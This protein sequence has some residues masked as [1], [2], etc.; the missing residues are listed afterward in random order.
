MANSGATANPDAGQDVSKPAKPAPTRTDY[1][2]TLFSSPIIYK[3]TRGL[4]WTCQKD[5]DEQCPFF[6]W[7]EQE[8]EA[9]EWLAKYGPQE[10]PET[11]SKKNNYPVPKSPETPWTKAKRKPV[12]REV[13]DE[14]ENGGPSNRKMNDGEVFDGG[15]EGMESPSRK[16][17]KTNRFSRPGGQTFNERLKEAVLPTPD[18]GGKGKGK[19][20][21]PAPIQAENTPFT[22]GRSKDAPDSDRGGMEDLTTNVLKL[23]RDEKVDLKESTELQIRHKIDIELALNAAKVRGYEETVSKLSKRLD[24]LETMLSYLTGDGSLDDPIELSD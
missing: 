4:V 1:V 19:A 15:E 13:S 20:I 7:V 8:A 22:L 14:N 2:C 17:A 11:P 10:A 24:E 3:L 23:L 6:V 5:R 12:S 18:S 21:E 16:A 9:K